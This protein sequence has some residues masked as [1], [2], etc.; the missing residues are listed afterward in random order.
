MQSTCACTQ[1]ALRRPLPAVYTQPQS[2]PSQQRDS[3]ESAS[4]SAEDDVA[5]SEASS[6]DTPED[7]QRQEAVLRIVKMFQEA[8]TAR[9]V[10]WHSP[11]ESPDD[12]AWIYKFAQGFHTELTKRDVSQ[13]ESFTA[14][15]IQWM[16]EHPP[17]TDREDDS[18]PEYPF[19]CARLY[20]EYDRARWTKNDHPYDA[21]FAW[22]AEHM[23][24]D[25]DG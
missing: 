21:P 20:A 3:D 25:D 6:S 5:L 7:P 14:W 11:D 17:L 10:E 8:L 19:S 23:C 2:F 16:T 4:E 9:N 24:P 12:C 15:V 1:P 18:G 22:L 13:H